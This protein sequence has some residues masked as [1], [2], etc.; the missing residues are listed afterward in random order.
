MSLRAVGYTC[1]ASMSWTRLIRLHLKSWKYWTNFHIIAQLGT[2]PSNFVCGAHI[3]F[4]LGSYFSFGKSYLNNDQI[5][6]MKWYTELTWISS[7]IRNFYELK[8][9]SFYLDSLGLTSMK[10]SI[11]E[12]LSI[13]FVLFVY[14]AIREIP[15]W[16]DFGLVD[17][18][19]KEMGSSVLYYE[20]IWLQAILTTI[21]HL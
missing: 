7:Q 3:L 14:P 6:E 5:S 20:G 11:S 16:N 2:F 18:I 12:Y 15:L 13:F 8:L 4:I 1:L 10:L 17:I 21:Y 19:Q 9:I